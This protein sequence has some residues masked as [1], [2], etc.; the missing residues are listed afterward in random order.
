[1]TSRRGPG[2]RDGY[3]TTQLNL[4][5]IPLL[6]RRPSPAISAATDVEEHQHQR[7]GE[8]QHGGQRHR[9]RGAPAPSRRR[10]PARRPASSAAAPAPSRTRSCRLPEGG[11]GCQRVGLQLVID[12]RRSVV[13]GRPCCWCWRQ[14][15][16]RYH[17]PVKARQVAVAADGRSAVQ[18]FACSQGRDQIF[19]S[20][21]FVPSIPSFLFHLPP[22]LPLFSLFYPA[23]K[24]PL[25]SS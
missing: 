25:K 20:G 1:M 16:A 9:R 21:C 15:Q 3:A 10:G 14:W 18:S 2:R 4:G 8:V 19:I 12:L 23:S 11:H 24:W 22:F 6:S 13:T 5:E 17:T 7:A